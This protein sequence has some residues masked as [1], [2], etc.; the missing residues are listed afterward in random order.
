MRQTLAGHCHLL[1]QT[2]QVTSLSLCFLCKWKWFN[3][4]HKVVVRIK[5]DRG[6]ISLRLVWSSSLGFPGSSVDKESA[7]QCKRCRFDPWVRKIPWRR[8]WQLTPIF[9]P[10][11]S[12]GQRRL[13]GCSPWGCTLLGTT[14]QLGTHS[15]HLYVT[16]EETKAL[17]RWF[18][19]GHM[20][21]N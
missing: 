18:A 13:V 2:N 20:N 3:P 15:H 17:R 14:E 21:N 16:E 5:W 11:T 1:H 19:N 7:C 4:F 6:A 12:S 10:E 8:K 9:L